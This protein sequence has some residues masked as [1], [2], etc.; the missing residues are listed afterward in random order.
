MDE[1]FLVI[2]RTANGAYKA[3]CP[4]CKARWYVS[5]DVVD[6]D[7]VVTTLRGCPW[8]DQHAAEALIDQTK[9]GNE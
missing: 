4:V 1:T 5:T 8:R 7:C 9:G 2:L 3:M 6:D